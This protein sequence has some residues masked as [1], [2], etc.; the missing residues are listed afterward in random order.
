[1]PVAGTRASTVVRPL[2]AA[3]AALLADPEAFTRATGLALADGWLAFPEALGHVVEQARV[4]PAEWGSQLVV[5]LETSTV[6]GLGGFKGPPAGGAVEVGYSVAP[7]HRGRGH[8]RT[9]VAAWLDQAAAAGVTA[10]LAHTLAQANASTRVL[11]RCG[12]ARVAT[13]TDDELGDLWRWRRDL[14]TPTP[15]A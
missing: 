12:F 14:P 6:V 2:S 11:E 9:A 8:A 3:E 1:M 5:D 4:G 15:A 7:A 13:V 10:V